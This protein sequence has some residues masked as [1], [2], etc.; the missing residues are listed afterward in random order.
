[1][2]VEGIRDDIERFAATL[3]QLPPEEAREAAL[4]LLHMLNLHYMELDAI[5][6]NS[7]NPS[8]Q[9]LAREFM[10]FIEALRDATVG[11]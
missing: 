10:A 1:M 5:A 9:G 7:S 11:A 6:S 3:E 4:G 2:D 8:I